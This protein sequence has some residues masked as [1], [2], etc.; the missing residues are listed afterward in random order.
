M[1]YS[2]SSYSTL[3]ADQLQFLSDTLQPILERFELEFERK[4]YLPTEK[5]FV[6]VR[7]DTKQLLRTDSKSLAE[8]YSKLFQVGVLSPNEIRNELDLES[9]DYGDSRF[10]QVN[11]QKLEDVGKEDQQTSTSS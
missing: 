1:D 10:V 8:Y 6:D 9:V 4:L 5:P 2:K 3:E 11:L 7:F